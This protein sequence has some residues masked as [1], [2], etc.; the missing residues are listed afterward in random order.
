MKYFLFSTLSLLCAFPAAAQGLNDDPDV[1]YVQE[2]SE[3]PI[4]LK[5]AK[6]GWVFSSK[7]GGRKR[8]ALQVNSSVELVGF[9]EK[10]YQIR[11]KRQNGE[12][13]SGWVSPAALTAKDK[14]FAKKFKAV[15]E[16]QIVV[17]ELIASKELAIGMTDLEVSKVLGRPTKSKVRR[18][19][20]GQSSTL[21]Y[22]DYEI[23]NH[24]ANFRDP[25][26]GGVYRKLTHQ[27]KEEKSKTVVEFE[28]GIVVAIEE[29]EDN[30]KARR[31]IVAIPVT[32][33][34]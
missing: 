27:T 17:R 23:E 24:Y 28:N 13:V 18:T 10:A 5:V 14:E 19:A 3:K 22:I 26:T 2:F 9:T 16:R 1:V 25:T 33:F 11:G 4:K 30:G 32:F 29:S 7:K 21:E 6:A 31:R 15:F 12:G 20:K 34:W 8:G